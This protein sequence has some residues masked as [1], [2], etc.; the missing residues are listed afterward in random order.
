MEEIQTKYPIKKFKERTSKQRSVEFEEID[1]DLYRPAAKCA[2]FL[3]SESRI[4]HWI[5]TFQFRYYESL[6][7]SG[8]ILVE[9]IDR[10]D[11][12]N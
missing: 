6:K 1:L 7:D 5:Q 10:E 12:H 11:I 8:N 9:W 4:L 3:T 2:S